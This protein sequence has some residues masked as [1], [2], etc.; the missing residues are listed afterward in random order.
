VGI[1][2]GEYTVEVTFD[3]GPLAGLLRSS[4]NLKFEGK[5]VSL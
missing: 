4:T 1:P 5:E 2:E 3:T